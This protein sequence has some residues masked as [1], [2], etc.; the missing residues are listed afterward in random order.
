MLGVQEIGAA[1]TNN[2]RR[3]MYA[4]SA[5]SHPQQSF[6]VMSATV[7]PHEPRLTTRWQDWTTK[8]KITILPKIATLLCSILVVGEPSEIRRGNGE[9]SFHERCAGCHGPDGRAQT[10][11]GKKAGAADLTSD[12]V[13]KQDDLHIVTVVKEGKGNMPAFGGKLSDEE[14]HALITYVRQLGKRR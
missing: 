11:M 7:F 1:G 6:Y 9:A 4:G 12:V 2:K 13:Q 8:M 10:E 3:H 14:I 5:K